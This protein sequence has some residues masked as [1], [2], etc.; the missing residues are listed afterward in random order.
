MESK[1]EVSYHTFKGEISGVNG[2]FTTE[3]LAFQ[4]RE[5]VRPRLASM[6]SKFNSESFMTMRERSRKKIES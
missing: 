3:S 6:L 4:G 5:E 2:G 1:E